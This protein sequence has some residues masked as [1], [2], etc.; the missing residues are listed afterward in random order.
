ME[1]SWF[2]TSDKRHLLCLNKMINLCPVCYCEVCGRQKWEVCTLTGL[3]VYVQYRIHFVV[4]GK[5][6]KTGI[7]SAWLDP[8]AALDLISCDTLMCVCLCV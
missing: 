7:A 3:T 6:E 4:K 5:A 1:A 2:M 8:A